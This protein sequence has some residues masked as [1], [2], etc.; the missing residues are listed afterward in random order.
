MRSKAF[1][2]GHPVAHSRSPLIHGYWFK[3]YGVNG[4]YDRHEVWPE[5]LPDFIAQLRAGAFAGGNVTVP[6]KQAARALI[7]EIDDAAR[8]IGAVNTLVRRKDVLFGTNTDWYGFLANLDARA[9]GW[10]ARP[11]PALVL[12]AGGSA[13]A[14]VYAL[15]QRGFS[16]IRILNRSP[17]RAESLVAA[18]DPSI[19]ARLEGHALNRF[20]DFAPETRI[21]VNTTT[22]GM[23]GSRFDDLPLQM[24][25][26]TTIVADIVYTPLVTP[27]LADAAA[28]GLKTVDGLGMLLH[29]AVPGFEAWFGVRPEVTPDLRELIERDMG[30]I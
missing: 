25:P 15:S 24:L 30:L 2:I 12:G 22:I 17:E 10:D 19:T 6:H 11:G 4:S 29:Q 18:R 21:L 3:T 5:D 26:E 14:I 20:A 7:D 1:V 9:P 13:R 27:L 23:H 28:R 16:P 8:A